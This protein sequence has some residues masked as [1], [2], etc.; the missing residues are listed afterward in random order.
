MFL[1][2]DSFLQR[3]NL[4][5]KEAD[6]QASLSVL[7]PA[8]PPGFLHHH[9]HP[10]RKN[11]IKALKHFGGKLFPPASHSLRLLFSACLPIFTWHIPIKG[12]VAALATQ[13]A[14]NLARTG[15]RLFLAQTTTA[16]DRQVLASSS[17]QRTR[18]KQGSCTKLVTGATY[19]TH[20][21]EHT[22]THTHIVRQ[23]DTPER[24]QPSQPQHTCAA[25][26]QGSSD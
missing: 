4:K 23:T 12:A 1:Q 7:R 5:F 21:N 10:D 13:M 6:C 8:G 20:T 26:P 22:C 16:A 11:R 9:N 25:G 17:S 24:G 2:C 15:T 19:E 18:R 14:I 3:R